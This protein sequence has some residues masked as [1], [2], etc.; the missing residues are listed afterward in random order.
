[1]AHAPALCLP[2]WQLEAGAGEVQHAQ[3]VIMIESQPGFALLLVIGCIPDNT[4]VAKCESEN[5]LV[6]FIT[7]YDYTRFVSLPIDQSYA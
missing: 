4:A 3:T 1:M 5:L 2:Q 7:E 6:K